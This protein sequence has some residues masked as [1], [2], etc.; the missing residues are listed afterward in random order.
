[1]VCEYWVAHFFFD[2]A[3]LRG[4]GGLDLHGLIALHEVSDLAFAHGW[5][6]DSTCWG[7]SAQSEFS[8]FSGTDDCTSV[9]V[10]EIFETG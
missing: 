5:V 9:G 1:M 8:S 6:T 4:Q 2:S 7:S 3:I 10:D